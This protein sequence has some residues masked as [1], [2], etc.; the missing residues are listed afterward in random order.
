VKRMGTTIAQKK[1]VASFRQA[2][3]NWASKKWNS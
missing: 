1:R 3:G 2:P